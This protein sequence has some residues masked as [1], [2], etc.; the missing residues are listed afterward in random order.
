[1]PTIRV[2][3]VDP[4]TACRLLS[5]TL[6]GK[7]RRDL[8]PSVA[9]IGAEASHQL[10][11]PLKPQIH[12]AATAHLLLYGITDFNLESAVDRSVSS[13]AAR[14]PFRASTRSLGCSSNCPTTSGRQGPRAQ[15]ALELVTRMSTQSVAILIGTPL[16]GRA[17][18]AFWAFPSGIWQLPRAMP[19]EQSR[20]SVLQIVRKA[21][22]KPD[23]LG[24]PKPA[25]IGA[26]R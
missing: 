12:T 5:F 7:T 25:N 14:T 6:W 10:A 19:E 26:H 8:A 21:Q 22:P 4:P 9:L 16:F 15:S 17:R 11:L 23:I 18:A 24:L 2:G 3:G 1:M 20:R 13:R